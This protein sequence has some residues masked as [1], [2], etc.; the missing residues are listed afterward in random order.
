LENVFERKSFQ[1][2]L[3]LTIILGY[4]PFLFHSFFAFPSG[5]DFDYAV[6]GSGYSL[7]LVLNERY[8][9][10]GRYLSNFLVLANPMRW[11]SFFMYRVFPI[12]WI[13]LTYVSI[14]FA[15]HKLTNVS[16]LKS[17]LFGALVHL[18]CLA[19]LPG[20]NEAYFW[21]TGAVT[22]TLGI[23]VFIF[24][25]SLFFNNG[26]IIICIILQFLFSGFNETLGLMG[27]AFLLSALFFSSRRVIYLQICIQVVLILYVV[28][29]PGNQVRSGLFEIEQGYLSLFIESG[30]YFF[31]F[32]FEW[33]FSL[34]T[35]CFSI[36]LFFVP[37]RTFDIGTKKVFHLVT[38]SII[39]LFIVVAA[40]IFSTG[41]LGQY[42]TTHPTGIL[43]FLTLFIFLVWAKSRFNFKRANSLVLLRTIPL[44]LCSIVLWK[45]VFWAWK[46]IL[47]NQPQKYYQEQRERL[48]Y[49]N[50]CIESETDTCFIPLFKH[51]PHLL[52]TYDIQNNPEH[53][54]NKTYT[55][56]LKKKE[57]KILP[58]DN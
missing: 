23:C 47:S 50:T 38:F 1:V 13:L 57:L 46:D 2:V 42:R 6:L 39:A 32:L 25:I 7:E 33:I 11:D 41:M 52:F 22:Y 4:F 15:I 44:I 56:Y 48:E 12:V 3:A 43:F 55:N 40:P 19:V 8:R 10:N 54:L 18:I 53:W 29:A 35:I 26:N 20:V 27:M 9:W 24:W 5:D 30:A 45:N 37:I 36:I 34:P 58:A 31:R 51:Q 28:L 21:Y 17:L 14:T 49:L 16:F